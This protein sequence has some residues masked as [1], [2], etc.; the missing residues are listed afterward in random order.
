MEIYRTCI[1][2]V[3]WI[4]TAAISARDYPHG[5]NIMI[6]DKAFEKLK[7]KFFLPFLNT[8]ETVELEDLRTYSWSFEQALF[9]STL[10]FSQLKPSQVIVTPVQEGN[11]IQIKLINL[12]VKFWYNYNIRFLFMRIDVKGTIDAVVDFAEAT[13]QPRRF[14][15]GEFDVL[16]YHLNPVVVKINPK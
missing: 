9:D 4:F 10:H 14:E 16:T 12:Q 2:I 3:L 5:M 8:F 13:V 15:D 1:F 11:I 7:N 6:K